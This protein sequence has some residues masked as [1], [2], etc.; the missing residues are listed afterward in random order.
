M[1]IRTRRPRRLSIERLET[2]DVPASN[3]QITA[4]TANAVSTVTHDAVTG[5]DQGGIAVT[6]ARAFVTGQDA[7]GSFNLADLSDG[8]SINNR[9]DALT[10]NVRTGQ[11]YVLGN[12]DLFT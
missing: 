8:V 9:Y 4:L 6:G 1:S 11:A 7:T 10:G 2:R 5:D 12:Q 3:F